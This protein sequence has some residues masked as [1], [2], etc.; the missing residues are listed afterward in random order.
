MTED[1]TSAKKM[2]QNNY[3]EE[4]ENSCKLRTTAAE[5]LIVSDTL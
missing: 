5:L 1:R 3:S 2:G 4:T